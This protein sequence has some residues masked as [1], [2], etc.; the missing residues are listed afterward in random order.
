MNKLS[1]K[2]R[3]VLGFLF[4][5]VFTLLIG[6]LAVY[7]QMSQ[8]VII[9]DLVDNRMAKSELLHGINQDLLQMREAQSLLLRPGQSIAEKQRI[10]KLLD[11]LKRVTAPKIQAIEGLRFSQAENILWQDGK[12]A[13]KLWENSEREFLQKSIG[14]DGMEIPNPTALRRDIEQFIGDHYQGMNRL[15]AMLQSGVEYQGGDDPTACNFGKYLINFKPTNPRLVSLLNEMREHHNGFHS[16]I[17]RVKALRIMG[18]N[19]E[20]IHLMSEVSKAASGVFIGFEGLRDEIIKAEAMFEDL[21]RY[22]KDVLAPLEEKTTGLFSELLKLNEELAHADLLHVETSSRNL[23]NQVLFGAIG[24]FLVALLLGTYVSSYLTSRIQAATIELKT[25]VELLSHA[26]SQVSST[27]QEL[28]QRNSEQAAAVEQT[29][30]TMNQLA[31]T[32][33]RNSEAAQELKQET[34]DSL[35]SIDQSYQSMQE[36]IQAMDAIRNGAKQAGHIIHSIEEIAFQTN[37]LALNAAVEA[38]RAGEVGAGFAVVAD[39]VRNLAQR[40]SQSAKDSQ[41]QLSALAREV[42]SGVDLVQGT[43]SRFDKTRT[44]SQNMAKIIDQIAQSS[45]EQALGVE[46]VNSAIAELSLTIQENSASSEEAASAAQETQ[47]T[48]EKIGEQ[49]LELTQLV[50]GDR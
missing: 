20:S 30:A 31:S 33:K 4:V 50:Y 47:D 11:E 46:Q 39:E 13:L 41:E 10:Y 35:V 22:Q 1:L 45:E 15:Y 48:G 29:S 8:R 7:S 24:C 6:A 23:V 17:G 16:S 9:Q 32:I 21:S 18:R 38:A 26:S 44:Q 36:T 40:A 34:E 3:L 14:L 43:R 28:A 5:S 12:N 19:T 49:V 37:L 2:L 27:S 42:Q 25:G